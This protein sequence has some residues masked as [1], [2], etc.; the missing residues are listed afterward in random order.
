[1][2][3]SIG[4]L[5]SVIEKEEINLDYQTYGNEDDADYAM[6]HNGEYQPSDY[7][8]MEETR[9]GNSISTKVSV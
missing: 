6:D 9:A 3:Q 8:D 7:D 1:M 2:G 4:R 5:K